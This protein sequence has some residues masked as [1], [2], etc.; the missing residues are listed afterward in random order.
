M[1]R[2]IPIESL[3]GMLSCKEASLQKRLKICREQIKVREEEAVSLKNVEK[4]LEKRLDN[5]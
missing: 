2:T 3:K 1:N 5:E 4:I